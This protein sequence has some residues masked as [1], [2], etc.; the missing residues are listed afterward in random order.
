MC[1]SVLKNVLYNFILLVFNRY[2]LHK[3]LVV[4]KCIKVFSVSSYFISSSEVASGCWSWLS[5]PAGHM[6]VFTHLWKVTYDTEGVRRDGKRALVNEERHTWCSD[7]DRTV[8]IATFALLSGYVPL[9]L[10][11]CVCVCVSAAPFVLIRFDSNG[12]QWWIFH[13]A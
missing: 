11:V 4:I 6:W 3:N 1:C 2:C 5:C 13:F 9:S 12:A 7:G 10:S 8:L